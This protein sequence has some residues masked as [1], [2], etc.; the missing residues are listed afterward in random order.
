[1]NFYDLLLTCV[2]K[3]FIHQLPQICILYD[4]DTGDKTYK[5]QLILWKITKLKEP[6]T[7]LK[8]QYKKITGPND[9][10]TKRSC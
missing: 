8:E 7:E 3:H 2:H 1:M 10:L 9:I 5:T 4:R 6:N